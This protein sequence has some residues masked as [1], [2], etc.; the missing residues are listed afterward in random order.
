MKLEQRIFDKIYE[1]I[2]SL[3]ISTSN[4]FRT[5]NKYASF[6]EKALEEKYEEEKMQ[7][8]NQF[9]DLLKVLD[10]IKTNEEES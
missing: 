8:C 10:F 7:T 6:E 9:E 3:Y 2:H 4:A 5:V 1:E